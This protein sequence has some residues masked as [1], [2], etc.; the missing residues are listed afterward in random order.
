MSWFESL[1]LRLFGRRPVQG[2]V[3]FIDVE[4]AYETGGKALRDISLHAE[5]GQVI[6]LVGPTGCG[7][8]TLVNLIFALYRPTA[9]RIE[10]DG[11]DIANVDIDSLRSAVGIVTQETFLFNGSILENVGFRAQKC[12]ARGDRRGVPRRELPR[13]HHGAQRWLRC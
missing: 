11:Q 1:T 2:D 13:V 4:F 5:C 10:I 7:K 3:R 12:V 8:T 6:A 9:G